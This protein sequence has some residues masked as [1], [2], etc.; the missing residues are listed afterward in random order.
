[1]SEIYLGNQFGFTATVS[2]PGDNEYHG[3]I[4]PVLMNDENE[5]LAAGEFQVV[6]LRQG[7]SCTIDYLGTFNFF[8]EDVTE[9]TYNFG[10]VDLLTE[11]LYS[12]PVPVTV[13][14][15]PETTTLSRPTEIITSGNDPDH[16]PAGD[17][18]IATEVTCEEG[19]Y[20]SPM[21]NSVLTSNTLFLKSGEKGTASVTINLKG[22]KEGTWYGG[23]FYDRN[24]EVL[25]QWKSF[26]VYDDDSSID[27]ADSDT[28]GL[29]VEGDAAT[30]TG[31]VSADVEIYSIDGVRAL[32]AR[33][34]SGVSLASLPHGIYMVVIT[35]PDGHR[36]VRKI[37]R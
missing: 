37:I 16:L 19:Y 34:T 17:V 21:L 26:M 18:E 33:A 29:E 1:M 12:I 32:Y 13:H 5:F 27:T 10:I 36:A 31:A 11:D 9:G 14:E 24:F 6:E 20:G 4:C 35:T 8:I 7:E 28:I 23:L 25:T 2:N 3:Y 15:E 22:S 30:V